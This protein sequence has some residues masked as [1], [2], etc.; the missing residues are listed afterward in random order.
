[1]RERA[2]GHYPCGLWPPDGQR[3]L[4]QIALSPD[5]LHS[6]GTV[7]LDAHILGRLQ[8]LRFPA[9]LWPSIIVE[10]RYDVTMT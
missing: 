3:F 8:R 1:M 4:E 2:V 9:A 5:K 6:L 10:L 7:N